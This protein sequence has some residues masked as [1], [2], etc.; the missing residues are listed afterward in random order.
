MFSRISH[1]ESSSDIFC[2]FFE[3]SYDGII[4]VNDISEM[5]SSGGIEKVS[6]KR[7]ELMLIEG[8]EADQKIFSSIPGLISFLILMRILNLSTVSSNQLS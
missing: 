3:I 5:I 1:T 2:I 7:S 8:N 6:Q 4:S